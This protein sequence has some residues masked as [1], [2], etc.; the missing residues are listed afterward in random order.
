MEEA[1]LEVPAMEVANFAAV[2]CV[3][4][5]PDGEHVVLGGSRG[6]I[7]VFNINTGVVIH[8][9]EGNRCG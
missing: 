6:D 7:F 4:A 1:N 8:K 2:L 5:M 9:F 3:A